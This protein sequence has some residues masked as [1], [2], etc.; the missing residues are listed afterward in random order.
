M[1]VTLHGLSGGSHEVY[2]SHVL[3]PIVDAGWEAFV[4]NSR[5]CAKCKITSGVLLSKMKGSLL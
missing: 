1:L 3:R 5:G 4:V 2:L